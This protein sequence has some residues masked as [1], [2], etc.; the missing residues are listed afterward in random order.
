MFVPKLILR[1]TIIT[2][3][4]WFLPGEIIDRTSH[5]LYTATFHWCA[6]SSAT[7][8]SP[9]SM[10]RIAVPHLLADN[11]MSFMPVATVTNSLTWVD[12][13]VPKEDAEWSKSPFHRPSW[14]RLC[15]LMS[16]VWR[17]LKRT[18][19][20]G[21]LVLTFSIS[22]PD[23]WSHEPPR[24][25]LSVLP[26]TFLLLLGCGGKVTPLHLQIY[27]HL[28]ALIDST[29][30]ALKRRGPSI[31]A[32]FHTDTHKHISVQPQPQSCIRCILAFI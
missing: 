7:N 9:G 20:S 30:S 29:P 18:E 32:T 23:K 31:R 11:V 6:S 5:F 17:R 3:W 19:H 10:H 8:K 4:S 12:W 26:S 21:Y 15:Q 27:T 2:L 13:F 28:Q 24:V 22:T 25:L 16:Y 14:H 1:K